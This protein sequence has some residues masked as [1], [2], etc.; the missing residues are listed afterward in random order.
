MLNINRTCGFQLIEILIRPYS[1]HN[2][3]ILILRES[4]KTPS[5]FATRSLSAYKRLEDKRIWSH[6]FLDF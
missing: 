6:E 3:R 2:S 5:I 4:P 1:S